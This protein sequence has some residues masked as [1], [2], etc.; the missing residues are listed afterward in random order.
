MKTYKIAIDGPA[1][2][3]KSSTAKI[4][5]KKLSFIYVDTGAMYRAVGVYCIKN[6]LQPEDVVPH[7]DNINIEIKYEDETQ[8]VYLNGEDVT[9]EIRTPEGSIYASKVAV[10]KE[11]RVKLVSMQQKMGET[12]NVVMDG[13]DIGNR[14]FPDADIKIFLTAS[15]EERAKR[16]YEELN[17]TVPYDEILEDIKFR[18][19]NDSTREIDP[20]RPASD[21]VLIDN[22]DLTL[23]ET[24]DK[25]YNLCIKKVGV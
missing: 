21:A 12:T 11:V 13:R 9:K 23:E 8:K 24:V 6:N 7:L 14:V 4:V 17:K 2:V 19:H 16:R 22:S 18:D 5:A 20:L 1:G 15:C 25:I 3:G 10:I